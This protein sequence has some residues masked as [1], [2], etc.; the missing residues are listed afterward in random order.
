MFCWTWESPIDVLWVK[1]LLRIEIREVQSVITEGSHF[2]GQG[3]LFNVTLGG[4]GDTTCLSFIYYSS[5]KYMYT[6]YEV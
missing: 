3:I 1:E 6:T 4:I 2:Y 5:V